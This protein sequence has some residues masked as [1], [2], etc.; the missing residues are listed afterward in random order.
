[1]RPLLCGIEKPTLV[2]LEA[3]AIIA[4]CVVNNVTIESYWSKV[5]QWAWEHRA[6]YLSPVDAVK[7]GLAWRG[8]S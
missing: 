7:A 6:N 8:I 5:A 4:E 3:A 2:E 1:M